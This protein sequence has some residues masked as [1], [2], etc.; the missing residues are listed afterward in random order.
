MVLVASVAIA[1]CGDDDG[2]DSG[3]AADAG[4]VIGA[5]GPL[6]NAFE[7]QGFSQP[8]VRRIGTTEDPAGRK[9]YLITDDV[10]TIAD[11]LTLVLNDVDEY[12]TAEFLAV[13]GPDPN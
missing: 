9:G 13:G 5:T 3:S 11:Y 4:A 10:K 12:W 8:E 1:G 7:K 2:D 6:G